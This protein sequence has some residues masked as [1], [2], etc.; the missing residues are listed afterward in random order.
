MHLN[1]DLVDYLSARGEETIPALLDLRRR[2]KDAEAS[3]LPPFAVPLVLDLP[4]H[5][6]LVN[7]ATGLCDA[8]EG[9]TLGVLGGLEGAMRRLRVHPAI[10]PFIRTEIPYRLRL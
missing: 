8:L 7:T 5:A 9:A 1:G 3:K 4:E 6:L 2:L 10:A